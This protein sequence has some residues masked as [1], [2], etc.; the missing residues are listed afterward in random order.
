MG[1][2]RMLMG[3]GV[4]DCAS[5]RDCWSRTSGPEE[6]E[7]EERVEDKERKRKRENEGG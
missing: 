7:E 5:S 1:S 2:E 4:K 6:E 3:G